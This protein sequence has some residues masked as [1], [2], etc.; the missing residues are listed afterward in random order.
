MHSTFCHFLFIEMKDRNIK[1]NINR[2][3]YLFFICMS[4]MRIILIILFF[5]GPDL[6]NLEERIK[7][8]HIASYLFFSLRDN[9]AISFFFFF[10]C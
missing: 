9:C 5:L 1:M 6:V 2:F 10:N 3:I 7:W 4:D 8:A